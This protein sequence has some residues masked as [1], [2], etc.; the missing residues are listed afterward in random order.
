MSRGNVGT[1]PRG[2]WLFGFA[3]VAALVAGG[4][5]FFNRSEKL[6][7]VPGGLIFPAVQRGTGRAPFPIPKTTTSAMPPGFKVVESK[8]VELNSATLA[9][10][11]TIPRITPEYARKIVAGRP[12]QSMEDLA[13]TGIPR[14]ILND[15]S[16]PAVIFVGR[17]G[18]PP[19]PAPRGNGR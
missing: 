11:E 7:T 4:Y 1:G 17:R 18:A 15:I 3:I 16:P 8:V 19:A 5:L 12:Y 9:E 2:R 6:E 13:R 14:E 10:I